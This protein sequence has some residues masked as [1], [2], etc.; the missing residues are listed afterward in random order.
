MIKGLSDND[1]PLVLFV[2]KTTPGYAG[3]KG[4]LLVR[5][6]VDK[7]RYNLFYLFITPFLC[8]YCDKRYSHFIFGKT[9]MNT[10]ELMFFP[11]YKQ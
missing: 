5:G 1:S 10:D 8:F 11:F 3:R 7:K 2:I 4:K 9:G 6:E